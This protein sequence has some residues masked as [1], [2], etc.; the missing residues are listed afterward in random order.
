MKGE[1]LIRNDCVGAILGR[2]GAIIQGIRAKSGAHLRLCESTDGQNR[3]IQ[4]F[5]EHERVIEIG[6]MP[7][8]YPLFSQGYGRTSPSQP[9][10]T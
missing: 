3:L 2:K 4:I 8:I 5:G 6:H 1:I 7:C 10:N 9:Y